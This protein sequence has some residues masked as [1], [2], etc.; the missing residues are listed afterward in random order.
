MEERDARGCGGIISDFSGNIPIPGGEGDAGDGLSGC[1]DEGDR[2]TDG[3]DALDIFPDK[4]GRGAAG[5]G[6][7]EQLALRRAAINIAI[8]EVGTGRPDGRYRTANRVLPKKLRRS[9]RRAQV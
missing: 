8:G 1:R 2:R 3:D 6:L 4:T 5:A 7:A 9:A